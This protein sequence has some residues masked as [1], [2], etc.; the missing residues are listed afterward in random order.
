MVEVGFE[1]ELTE[2]SEGSGDLWPVDFGVGPDGCLFQ[3]TDIGGKGWGLWGQ[4]G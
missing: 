1:C 2:L 4:T 3:G